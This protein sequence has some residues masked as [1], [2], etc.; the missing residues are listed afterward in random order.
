ME[1]LFKPQNVIQND[2]KFNEVCLKFVM[3]FEKVKTMS[4]Y[5]FLSILLLPNLSLLLLQRM[6]VALCELGFA[7][8]QKNIVC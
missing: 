7:G 8:Q 4:K 6:C 3:N 1:F 2:M 5:F